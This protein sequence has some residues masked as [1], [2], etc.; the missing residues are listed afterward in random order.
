MNTKGLQ[1]GYT[2]SWFHCMPIYITIIYCLITDLKVLL[3]KVILNRTHTSDWFAR[4]SPKPH[5]ELSRILLLVRYFCSVLLIKPIFILAFFVFV[6]FII[7]VSCGAGTL[8]L[9]TRRIVSS[10]S[11]WENEIFNIFISS[12]LCRGKARC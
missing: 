6:L 1:H 4:S 12:L 2:T 7:E 5:F 10:N 9:W 3:H 11:T 8:V